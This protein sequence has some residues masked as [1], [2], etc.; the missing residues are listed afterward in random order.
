MSS[1]SSGSSICSTKDK[2]EVVIHNNKKLKSNDSTAVPINVVNHTNSTNDRTCHSTSR[3]K[4]VKGRGI[5]TAVSAIP[6]LRSD[7]TES[8]KHK[9]WK[10]LLDSGSDGDIVFIKRSERHT[11]DVHKRLHPQ[12]WRTSNGV[13]ETNKVANLQLTLPKFNASKTMSV[14]PD[15]QFIE[16]A[17]LPLCMP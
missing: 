2:C 11:I 4:V 14:M 6:Q 5:V 15:V 13:F 16:K 12:K 7:K 17:S 1:G 8:T 9:V 3:R 10:V